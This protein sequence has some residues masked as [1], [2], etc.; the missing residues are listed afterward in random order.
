MKMVKSLLL[1]SAAGLVAV[2]GSTGSRSSRQG[3][4]GRVREGLQPVRCGVL[5]HPRHR[6][7]HAAWW[8]RPRRVVVGLRRQHDERSVDQLVHAEHPHQRRSRRGVARLAPTS[9]WRPGSR[10]RTARCAPTSTSASNG[11]NSSDF[12]ANRAFIQI[13]GFTVGLASSYF[14][15][16]SVAAIA[17]LVD[18]SSDTGD[19]GQRVM[20]YTASSAT[21]MS[22]TMSAEEPEA[23]RAGVWNT[24][25]ASTATA[26][27]PSATSAP[28]SA[29]TGDRCD[30]GDLGPNGYRRH[31]T[32]DPGP[33]QV[34]CAGHRGQPSCR[35]RLGQCPGDGCRPRGAAAATTAPR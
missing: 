14:D 15:H 27:N 5:L 33:A 34:D 17:Y 9:R 2:C 4:T 19:G 18:Q 35:R 6:H 20:A 1:G 22:A 7:L 24:S 26:T 12:N 11:N 13:A 3:Q 29:C 21:A 16:Y 31:R 25:I 28:R 32:D 23:K 10:P 8:L 30:H